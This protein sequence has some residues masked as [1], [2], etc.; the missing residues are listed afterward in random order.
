MFK[1]YING[2]TKHKHAKA[3]THNENGN[4][5]N[6]THRFLNSITEFFQ[7]FEVFRSDLVLFSNVTVL[8]TGVESV[9]LGADL[10]GV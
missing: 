9:Y 4:L 2:N 6:P 7:F 5:P 10:A 8:Y 1:F 3:M